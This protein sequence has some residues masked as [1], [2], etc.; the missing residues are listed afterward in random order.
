MERLQIDAAEVERID[1]AL[2]SWRQGD[3]ALDVHW[4]IHAADP[5]HPLTEES[6]QASGEGPTT[7]MSDVEGVVVVTQTCDIVR[8]CTERPFIEVVPLVA[9]SESM[10]QEIQKGRRPAYAFIPA[11][12]GALLVADLDRVMTVEKSLVATWTRTAGWETD[13]Q[14]REITQALARKRV[15]FAFPDDFTHFVQKLQGRLQEK[16]GKQTEEGR[17][18][19]ALREIRVRATPSWDAPQIELT[20]WFILDEG[21]AEPQPLGLS[22]Q[23]DAW[24]KL[25]PAAGRFTNVSG[26][27]VMLEDLTARDYVESDRL[28]LDHLSSRRG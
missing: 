12:A 10:L 3:V 23:L 11:V 26:F 7:L 25:I 16:H 14:G 18:L 8:G 22:A 4:F 21:S 17:A 1:T 27:I 6:A 28:D 24:L 20:F 5:R 19:R 9:V 2:A 15:R 13:L